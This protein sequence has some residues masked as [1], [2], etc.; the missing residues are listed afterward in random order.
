MF[1]RLLLALAMIAALVGCN[2]PAGTAN[3]TTNV[4][5]STPSLESPADSG[6]ESAEPSEEASEEPSP[7]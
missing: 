7:S 1:K 3:P 2:T 5:P 6:L 4:E